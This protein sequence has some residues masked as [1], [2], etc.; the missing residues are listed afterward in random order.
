[1]SVNAMQPTGGSARKIKRRQKREM[2]RKRA[3]LTDTRPL[4]IM[5]LPAVIFTF[6]FA[7]LPLFGLVMAFQ[8]FKPLLGFF[9]SKWVGLDQFRYLFTAPAFWQ[10]MRNTFI[11][12]FFKIVLGIAVPLLLSI[13]LNEVK[14]TMFKRYVQTTVFIPYFFSW[15]ILG[16]IVLEVFSYN[17]ILNNITALLGNEPTAFLVDNRYFRT[18]II[19]TDVWKG[20]G[21]NTVIFLAAIT[22]IDPTLYEAA[23]VDG[24]GRIRQLTKITLPSIASMIILLTI[25][26]LGGILNAGFEQILILS[27]P[28]VEKTVDI[29]DTYVY[30]LG[31][32]RMQ[33]SPA[34]AAGL[35]KSVVALVF[36]GGSYLIAYKT[37][38]YR[39]F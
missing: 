14:N 27:N 25:L 7:Y 18:I 19:G 12:A 38:D 21:Y 35:F 15:A 26:G 29:I 13:L 30:R 17:G 39:V 33:Y 34:A 1:M 28:I 4:H 24:A 31:I 6:L 2:I 32:R 5:L 8:N 37:T 22:N 23:Q 11:I 3:R 36:V 20:M 16:G 9:D 10:S